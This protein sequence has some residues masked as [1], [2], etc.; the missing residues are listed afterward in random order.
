MS[1]PSISVMNCGRAFSFASHLA[2]VVIRL[3]IARE[4]LH[5]RELHALRLIGDDLLLGPPRR[6][7]AAFQVGERLVRKVNAE[8][9][10]GVALC[11]RFQRVLVLRGNAAGPPKTA[12]TAAAIAIAKLQLRFMADLLVFVVDEPIC[13]VYPA[14]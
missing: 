7:D 1:T 12:S 14:I 2:P 8:G 4:L 10:D 3:P 11:Q 13:P 6:R 5:R 9:A